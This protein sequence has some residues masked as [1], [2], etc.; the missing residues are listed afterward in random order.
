MLFVD[1]L[2]LSLIFYQRSVGGVLYAARYF[3][4]R[5]IYGSSFFSKGLCSWRRRGCSVLTGSS[6]NRGRPCTHA[7]NGY[8]LAPRLCGS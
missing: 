4:G 8:I 5:K 3:Y 6:G 1:F 7:H 2:L